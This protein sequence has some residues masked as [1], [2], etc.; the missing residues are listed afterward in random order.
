M[1]NG[2]VN[3][4]DL[5]PEPLTDV[6]FAPFGRVAIG[7]GPS[8]LVNAGTADR[9]DLPGHFGNA[10]EARLP[11]LAI[12]RC[13]AQSSPVLVR[14]LERHPLTTQTFLPLRIGRWLI[15]VAPTGADGMPVPDAARAFVAGRGQGITYAIGVWHS[16]LIALDEPA[17]L[18]MLMWE[19]GDAADCEVS[20]LPC[21]L[22]I[23]LRA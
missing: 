5:A 13:R 12:Y 4:E 6:T 17:E 14:V 21:P 10:T 1:S 20:P 18:A 22:R 15:V 23:R 7:Q 3:G 8:R 19:A 9:F 2:K 16:P 11:A